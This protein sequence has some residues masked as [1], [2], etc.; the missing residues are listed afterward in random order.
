[1]N[2]VAESIRLIGSALYW[3]RRGYHAA[4]RLSWRMAGFVLRTGRRFGGEEYKA[5][6]EKRL[7]R[8]R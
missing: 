4:A 6:H 3:H 2:R 1:M 5:Y 7:R 8:G